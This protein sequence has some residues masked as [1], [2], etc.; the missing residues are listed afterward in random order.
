[1]YQVVEA[2]FGNLSRLYRY[3]RLATLLIHVKKASK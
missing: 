3:P 1:M 2:S